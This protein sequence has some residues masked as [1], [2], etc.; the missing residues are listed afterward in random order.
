MS[1][2]K[3]V[4]EEVGGSLSRGADWIAFAH[5]AALGFPVADIPGQIHAVRL[6]Q[7]RRRYPYIRRVRSDERRTRRRIR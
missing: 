4:L 2:M 7:Q 5:L 1:A 3:R 6:L